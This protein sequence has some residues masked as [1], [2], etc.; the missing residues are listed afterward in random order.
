MDL[1]LENLTR[2]PQG[3]RINQ[4]Q[5]YVRPSPQSNS[6]PNTSPNDYGGHGGHQQPRRQ[7]PY[8]VNN[9]NNQN[10]NY[11]PSTNYKPASQQPYQ[12]NRNLPEQTRFGHEQ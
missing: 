8:P 9:S 1:A 2:R 12:G 6:T 7:M 4:N 10:P 3:P 5:A 11:T